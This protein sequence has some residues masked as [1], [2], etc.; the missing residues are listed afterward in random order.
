LTFGAT[1]GRPH[2]TPD[3]VELMN[4]T[5]KRTLTT[6]GTGAEDANSLIQRL[7]VSSAVEIERVISEL[8]AMRASFRTEG[9]RVQRAA[10]NYAG[11]SQ[12]AMS[13]MRII[14]DGLLPRDRRPKWTPEDPG[15]P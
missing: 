2:A 3:E 5:N 12:A 7:S 8:Q 14:A 9:D 15:T 6:A 1:K 13:S 4:T 10:T 11:M